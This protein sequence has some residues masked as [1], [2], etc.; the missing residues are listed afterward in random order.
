MVALHFFTV[1]ANA[2]L[3]DSRVQIKQTLKE[4]SNRTTRQRRNKMTGCPTSYVGTFS[5]FGEYKETELLELER[6][7]NKIKYYLSLQ[8]WLGKKLYWI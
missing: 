7:K 5:F 6:N 2:G 8:H 3:S 4:T 1:S